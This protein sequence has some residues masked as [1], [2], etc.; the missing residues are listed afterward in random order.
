[1]SSPVILWI[2]LTSN[3]DNSGIT[4]S[5]SKKCKLI[6]LRD[7]YSIKQQIHKHQP[8][9]LCFDFDQPEFSGLDALRKTKKDFPSI[10]ILM[11]AEHNSEALVIWALRCRVWDYFTKPVNTEELLCRF[12]TLTQLRNNNK[13]RPI[14][15]PQ[16]NTARVIAIHETPIPAQFRV[17]IQKNRTATLPAIAYVESHF[18]EK[19]LLD[20]IAKHCSMKSSAFSYAFKNN[21]KLTF[22]EFLLRYRIRKATELLKHSDASV[23]EIACAVGFNDP[24]QFTRIFKR[25]LKTTPTEFRSGNHSLPHLISPDYEK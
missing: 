19:I 2:R 8:H 10:P 25:Y 20:V 1:M 5:L 22:R 15:K 12:K 13:N 24:S 16:K 23:L 7:I 18:H 6:L 17:C 3:T 4:E 11:L 14:T 9:A 21:H